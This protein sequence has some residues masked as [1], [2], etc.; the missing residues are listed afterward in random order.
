MVK[1]PFW[2]YLT[3]HA[4]ARRISSSK[5]ILRSG[6]HASKGF[7]PLFQVL[8]QWKV[9]T[10][11]RVT[12]ATET[13]LHN[14]QDLAEAF[15]ENHT[16]FHKSC[17]TVY[18][19]QKLNRKRKHAGSFNVRDAPETLLSL[20]QLKFESIVATLIYEISR[21]IVSSVEK[22]IAKRSFTDMKHLLSPKK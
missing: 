17:V 2:I 20:I 9:R 13:T 10:N 14:D 1:S 7:Q 22:K 6:S 21:Q 18:N 19:K 8:I 16:V 5:K 12:S 11:K 15:I 3:F 4:A